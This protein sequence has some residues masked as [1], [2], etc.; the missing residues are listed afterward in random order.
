MTDRP[1][2]LIIDDHPD[3]L[4]VLTQVVE[5]LV[6]G[7]NVV[8]ATSAEEGLA[9]ALE[10]N[11]DAA[12]IDVQ[13]PGMDGV[14]MCRMLKA[15]PL[16]RRMAVILI[17]SQGASAED[18]A[19]ALEA[20]ADDFMSRPIDNVELAARIK[21]V[22]RIKKA[23]DD[24]R[25]LNANLKSRVAE[26]TAELAFANRQL[27]AERDRSRNLVE[28]APTIIM[29]LDAQGH[30]V[31]FNPYF[32]ELSGFRLDEVKGKNWLETFVPERER[33]HITTVLE[34]AVTGA[35][36]SGT[37]SPVLTKDGMERDILW[38]NRTIRG[39]E[40]QVT[41]VLAIGQDIT[42]IRRAAGIQDVL[43]GILRAATEESDLSVL[44]SRIRDEIGTVIDT[45]NFYVAL[46]DPEDE[47]YRFPFFVGDEETVD[48]D[49][50]LS[51]PTSLTDYVRRTGKSLWMDD[52]IKA[53]LERRGEAE[54][55]GVPSRLWL[56]APL[57]AADRVIG[58]VAVQSYGDLHHFAREDLELLDAVADTTAIAICRNQAEQ[59]MTRLGRVVED[60]V[61]EVY[62]FDAEDLRFTQVNRAARGNLGYSMA[63]LK[64]MSPLDLKPEFTEET[65]A[66]VLEPLRSGERERLRFTTFHRR[67]D[68]S[69]YPVEM[70]LS[71]V[72]TG[73]DPIFVA[74][75][76]DIT[77][78]RKIEAELD[79]HREYL[80]DLIEERTGQLTRAK[81]VTEAVNEILYE[82]LTCKDEGG[83]SQ[84]C[85]GMARRLT[86]AA[87]GF[88]GEINER[89]RLDY[90]ALDQAALDASR[91][92]ETQA[93]MMIRDREVRGIWSTV[94]TSGQSR[95]INDPASHEDS[96]GV[97]EGHPE[98]ESFLGVPL[99]L[100]GETFG[101]MALGN[102]DDGFSE[103]DQDAVTAL[104]TA[105]IQALMRLRAEQ[106]AAREARDRQKALNLMVG[107][108]LRMAELKKEI[109]ARENENL[110]LRE[111]L[112]RGGG[113]VS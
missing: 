98:L 108:E 64:Q 97:P 101:I 82:A 103:A 9:L 60:S 23:E 59:Q 28:I 107:R 37:I 104:A 45:S 61:N 92:P 52:E 46:Y 25:S 16:I 21:V 36:T 110:R 65:F 100:R 96:V 91:I 43:L 76:L 78:R 31:T 10:K 73:G 42:D 54:M 15:N 41:G 5:S 39:D 19:R 74:I 14:E 72:S 94:I 27:R 70:Y 67:N 69:L 86:G 113:S 2:L 30:I 81:E 75:A 51:L 3:N 44:I 6:S 102:K 85:M 111:R 4:I 93:S 62:V 17:T 55:V 88:I 34:K 68:D 71:L 95:I 87:F 12:L 47:T 57:R 84:L 1:I 7:C 56:G 79:G 112:G 29:E 35:Q 66:E 24:L 26:R 48:P 40:G 80:E 8:S 77:E 106:K 83:L 32:E 50:R 22:L 105:F 53:D 109:E 18:K 58:V 89:G 63:E 38:F 49:E 13:M 90:F 33:G 11:P 99:I 20:G